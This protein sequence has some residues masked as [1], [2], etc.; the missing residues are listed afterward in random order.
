MFDVNDDMDELFRRAAE[1]YPLKTDNPDWE[2]VADG[3]KGQ[4]VRDTNSGW[5]NKRSG[6]FLLLLSLLPAAFICNHHSGTLKTNNK[7]MHQPARQIASGSKMDQP[8]AQDRNIPQTRS[9]TKTP[10]S[11]NSS[12]GNLAPNHSS[13]G[14]L[15][16]SSSSPTPSSRDDLN[17]KHRVTVSNKVT[18]AS[19]KPLSASEVTY[20]RDQHKL[21]SEPSFGKTQA[22]LSEESTKINVGV[23]PLSASTN[24]LSE[25]SQTITQNNTIPNNDKKEAVETTNV[26]D[27]SSPQTKNKIVK[28]KAPHLYAGII[29]N[30]DI[31][32]IKFQ[33][34]S[35]PGTGAGIIV[36]YQLNKRWS[37][38]SGIYKQKKFYYTDAKYYNPANAYTAPTYKLLSVDGNC[39]MLEVPLNV[40]YDFKTSSKSRWFATT[41]IS[42]YFMQ[43]ENYTYTSESWGRI[44]KRN[45]SYNNSS[46][47]WLSVVN[48]STGY[49]RQ[50]GR[51]GALRLEPY[52]KVPV[53]GF[54]WG[55]LPIMSGGLNVGY[56]RKVF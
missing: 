7:T 36:G 43:K 12:S 29:G 45:I 6:G 30:I 10:V 31:S 46:T 11:T 3:L 53:K 25:G 49:Q 51:S 42:T 17:Y 35:S 32:T 38:E 37:I 39:S 28:N 1:S 9:N 19:A 56:V 14:S 44:T 40:K 5:L 2:R 21:N 22:D 23:S 41:G 8:I 27:S 47:A 54:G 18:A 15:S 33:S 20:I 13:P 52:L 24:S 4:Q 34:L 48:L 50:L 16:L 26:N 55:R